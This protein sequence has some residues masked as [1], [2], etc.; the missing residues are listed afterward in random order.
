MI[1]SILK[2]TG[3]YIKLRDILS[4]GKLIVGK[5][6]TGRNYVNIL[7]STIHNNQIGILSEGTHFAIR[8]TYVFDNDI[9]VELDGRGHR[10]LMVPVTGAYDR[11]PDMMRFV[12]FRSDLITSQDGDDWSWAEELW[13]YGTNPYITDDPTLSSPTPIKFKY[14]YVLL[15]SIR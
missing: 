9:S 2:I 1:I 11:R 13:L 10:T 5:T 15:R 6:I 4:C 12:N 3:R 8:D 14:P 7:D